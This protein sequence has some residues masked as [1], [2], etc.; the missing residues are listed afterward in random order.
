MKILLLGATG[1]VGSKVLEL[2]LASDTISGVVAPTR[3]PL[4]A[5]SKLTNPVGP[6]LELF[7]NHVYAWHID[8]VICAL[9]STKAKAGSEEAFH[10]SDYALPLI[11]ASAAKASGVQTLAVVTAIG[12]STSSN[13]SYARTKGEL[14]RDMQQMNFESLTICR[15][16][17]IAGEREETRI[18]ESIALAASR[19]LAPILPRKFHI[20]PASVI[21]A[22]LLDSVIAAK[23][24]STWIYAE[25][26]N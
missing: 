13:F 26:M 3:K 21:A 23:P 25:Q 4:Q 8:A 6:I 7:A 17:I 5:H 15:P 1:L 9:G 22:A 20:N 2:A 19:S 12:A 14:E 10:H 11:F 18:G 16:S 24:G